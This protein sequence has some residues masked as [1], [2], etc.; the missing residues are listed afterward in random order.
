MAIKNAVQFIKE[1]RGELSRVEW[2]KFNEF[3]G[4][5]LVVL[6]LVCFFSIYLGLVDLG[7]SKLAKYIFT[8][9]GGY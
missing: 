4:S 3:A 2:P 5:T 9:Y 8:L 1:V 6:F 7:L